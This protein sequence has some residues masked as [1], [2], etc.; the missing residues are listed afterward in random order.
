MSD[1]D[2]LAL[3]PAMTHVLKMSGVNVLNNPK[4]LVSQ[5]LDIADS[6][7]PEV[8]IVQ[9]HMDEVVCAAL[10]E[11]ASNPNESSLHVARARIND[12]LRHSRFVDPALAQSTASDIVGG[13]ADWLGIAIEELPTQG[14]GEQDNAL[15]KAENEFLVPTATQPTNA[16]PAV[17]AP[18]DL[19]ST[20]AFAH[21]GQQS[22][23]PLQQAAHSPKSR[24]GPLLAACLVL[25]AAAIGLFMVFGP[26]R[27]P[28]RYTIIASVSAPGL[29]GGGTRIPVRVTGKSAKGTDVSQD[30]YLAYDGTGLTL[31]AG[32]YDVTV[33]GSPIASDGGLYY[34][35]GTVLSLE[36]PDA[37][38]ANTKL[39][40]PADQ[41]ITLRQKPDIEVTDQD[42]A[43]AK[44][45]AQKDSQN[46]ESKAPE[47][48]A[49]L[50]N[51]AETRRN[52]AV[53]A[54]K[55]ADQEK[56]EQEAREKAEREAAASQFDISVLNGWW[57]YDIGPGGYM[58][59]VHIQDGQVTVYS[60]DG[61]V[62][63]EMSFSAS[64]CVRYDNG[65][66]NTRG[67][68]YPGWYIPSIKRY[69]QDNNDT[70]LA[71]SGS[72]DDMYVRGTGFW[73]HA[74]PPS[75]AS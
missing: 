5:I 74:D 36:V 1:K 23:P 55:K 24:R 33:Q 50:A 65:V 15:D 60:S 67:P 45:W 31:E 37:G 30:A 29:D 40:V 57:G 48:A 52:E 34:V 44:Q 6:S 54:K 16:V 72:G 11:A 3:R 14:V 19:P 73:G 42:I 62:E 63:D 51:K 18:Q 35:D 41:T 8:R 32:S 39:E 66:Q 25:A 59:Y 49:E 38:D 26:F 53:E 10:V 22:A 69:L 68:A 43:D 56:A 17:Q 64:E 21:T 71:T 7:L 13:M 75:F 20:Q 9:R 70:L 58:H 2:Y 4:Q 46:Q 47:I 27:A 61:A 12:E 28:L